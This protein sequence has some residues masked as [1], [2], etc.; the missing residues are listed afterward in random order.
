M[1]ADAAKL[2]C[3]EIIADEAFRDSMEAAEDPDTRLSMARDRGFDF[4][5]DELEEAVAELASAETVADLLDNDD[6]AGFALG[7]FVGLQNHRLVPLYFDGPGSAANFFNSAG[8]V[9]I[10]AVTPPG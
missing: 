7:R 5:Q 10:I 1:S 8:Q 9:K 3:R 2:F 4:T 6:V